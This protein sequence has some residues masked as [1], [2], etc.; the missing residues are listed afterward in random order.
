M[1]INNDSEGKEH[2]SALIY[3]ERIF[4][5]LINLAI[6]GQFTVRK[7]LCSDSVLGANLTQFIQSL[8]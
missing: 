1:A 8:V 2:Q 7:E 5:I 3:L 6:C 4:D